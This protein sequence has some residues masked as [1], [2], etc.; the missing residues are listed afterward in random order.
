MREECVNVFEGFSNAQPEISKTSNRST[1]ASTESFIGKVKAF[2][3]KIR[4]MIFIYRLAK[5]FAQYRALQLL[6]ANCA[7]YSQRA[8]SA[9]V[10]PGPGV[11]C[12]R[13]CIRKHP[14][15]G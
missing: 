1:N 2:R 13:F 5:I 3:A 9:Y 11:D 7:S 8:S 10:V 14:V 15:I 6:K 4:G 12:S